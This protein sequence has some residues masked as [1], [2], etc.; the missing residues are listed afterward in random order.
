MITVMISNVSV[1]YL[2]FEKSTSQ[3]KKRRLII[4]EETREGLGKMDLSDLMEDG[5]YIC[6]DPGTPIVYNDGP[7]CKLCILSL[8]V[9][10]GTGG[11]KG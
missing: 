4:D 10:T 2:T 5:K 8:F 7:Y 3:M 6:K 11:K 1:I 9:K